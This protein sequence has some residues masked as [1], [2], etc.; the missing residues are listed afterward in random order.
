MSS[1]YSK[2]V[3]NHANVTVLLVD[4]DR[5]LLELFLTILRRE[6]YTVFPADNGIEAL[7]VARNRGGERIDILLIDVAMLYMSRIQLATKMKEAQSDIRVLLT[8]ALPEHEVSVRCGPD[9]KN[10]FLNE[11]IQHL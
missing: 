3:D 9:K 6:G 7:D 1:T 8:S 10:G 4:D 11:T 5:P 2:D